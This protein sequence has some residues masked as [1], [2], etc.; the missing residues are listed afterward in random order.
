MTK[1]SKNKINNKGLDIDSITIT[2]NKQSSFKFY[3]DFSGYNL[4][5][6]LVHKDSEK[7]QEITA[8]KSILT[9]DFQLT[10][11]NFDG[12]KDISVLYNCGSGGCAYW[13]WNYSPKTKQYYYNEELSGRLGLEMDAKTQQIIFHYRTGSSEESWE[14]YNYINDKLT[15]I[16]SKRK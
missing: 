1:V 6:I 14:Y 5:T 15:F 7:V 16:K 12:F 4:K 2:D 8:N 11:W 9:K 13:I 10:D 3:T